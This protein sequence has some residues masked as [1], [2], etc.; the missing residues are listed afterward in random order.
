MGF[1]DQLKSLLKTVN[2]GKSNVQ[3][4]ISLIESWTKYAN[5]LGL[6]EVEILGMA[7]F[8]S[9]IP[10]AVFI[11]KKNVDIISP[12]QK[13]V[14]NYMQ[15]S[16]HGANVLY[17][18][19]E[20]YFNSKTKNRDLVPVKLQGLPTDFFSDG[21]NRYLKYYGSN[22]NLFHKSGITLDFIENLGRI[23]L[24][25]DV[26]IP[27]AFNLG[28][29]HSNYLL[30]IDF[31]AASEAIILSN[32][33]PIYLA[34]LVESIP[35]PDNL[36]LNHDL[37]LFSK[38]LIEELRNSDYDPEFQEWVWYFHNSLFYEKKPGT[39]EVKQNWKLE[40]PDFELEMMIEVNK[41]IFLFYKSNRRIGNQIIN[42][43][44]DTVKDFQEY[45]NY[46]N[47]KMISNYSIEINR[48]EFRNIGEKTNYLCQ[49]FMKTIEI[50]FEKFSFG[51]IWSE[52]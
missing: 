44:G 27:E 13:V 7:Y 26:T 23:L 1:L 21:N 25:Y 6:S 18:Y 38:I 49:V 50:S 5:Q 11:A 46:V 51:A 15:S 9:A 31:P 17:L 30:S 45:F 19:R 48:N 4:D 24:D 40:N 2:S 16:N 37:W 14:S 36:A 33:L 35:R 34:T 52:K 29:T 39:T 43:S 32:V 28:H 10:T 42:K 8:N 3:L 20:F 12:L 47:N 22:D 41:S